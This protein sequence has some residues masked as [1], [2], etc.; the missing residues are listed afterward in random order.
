[1]HRR[2]QSILSPVHSRMPAF[3]FFSF[4]IDDLPCD[5]SSTKETGHWAPHVLLLYLCV[6]L[7]MKQFLWHRPSFPPPS[8]PRTPPSYALHRRKQ[9]ILSLVRSQMPAFFGIDDLPCDFSSTKETGHWALFIQTAARFSV[10]L[11]AMSILSASLRA[12]VS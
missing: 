5:F 6:F 3:C 2:K 12:T 9:P 4:C 8:P 7:F 1:L 11:T 10:C